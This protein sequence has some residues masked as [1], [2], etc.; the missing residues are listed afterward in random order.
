M[1]LLLI[2]PPLVRYPK[3]QFRLRPPIPPQPDDPFIPGVL[4]HRLPQQQQQ[5]LPLTLALDHGLTIH[6]LL[7][8]PQRIT[9]I[10]ATLPPRVKGT[11]RKT[12]IVIEK[13]NE[14]RTRNES[15]NEEPVESMIVS[16]DPLLPALPLVSPPC[17]LPLHPPPRIMLLRLMRRNHA[18]G[19]S[20]EC[21]LRRPLLLLPLQIEFLPHACF[22]TVSRRTRVAAV[23]Q[24]YHQSAMAAVIVIPR[25]A[26]DPN[27]KPTTL[28]RLR[29]PELDP[30][31][32]LPLLLLILM[33]VLLHH[34]LVIIIL[35]NMTQTSI[36]LL[37]L[38]L[39]LPAATVRMTK[40]RCL[41]RV[42]NEES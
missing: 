38:L 12:E 15:E 25:N 26:N 22:E 16:E 3:S 8:L 10:E 23:Q 42:P 35:E 29:R 28:L 34:H 9:P 21:L 27:L 39:L 2:L 20:R 11:K 41:I 18:F 19:K 37:P 40:K 13:E 17:L 7:R 31:P 33:K 6:L 5:A 30:L 36:G 4:L 24:R 1:N 14:T 32:V